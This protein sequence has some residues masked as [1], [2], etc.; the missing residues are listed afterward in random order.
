M[1]RHGRVHRSSN[2]RDAA[3]V[4]L[5]RALHVRVAALICSFLKGQPEIFFA[6][7]GRLRTCGFMHIGKAWRRKKTMHL[8]SGAPGPGGVCAVVREHG[9]PSLVYVVHQVSEISTSAVC[10]SLDA[11]PYF[12]NG[13]KK[14]VAS[15]WNAVRTLHQCRL[16]GAPEA[17]CERVGS[18]LE[19]I[20]S[21]RRAH[22]ALASHID[23]ARI[24]E[25]LIAAIGGPRD[26][27]ITREIV[28]SLR[29]RGYKSDCDQRN[30]RRHEREGIKVSLVVDRA[31]REHN[32]HL[33]ACGRWTPPPP[34]RQ[35]ATV[36]VDHGKGEEEE[37]E[38]EVLVLRP[39]DKEE[40]EE[41]Q[42]EEKEEEEVLVCNENPSDVFLRRASPW[43]KLS[44]KQ[45]GVA[46]E[47]RSCTTALGRRT[48]TSPWGKL[49][50]K[51]SGVAPVLRSRP[52]VSQRERLPPRSG[53]GSSFRT[54]LRVQRG[55]RDAA[56][57]QPH[58]LTSAIRG[59]L[60]NVAKNNK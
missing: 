2:W 41:E 36:E 35:K 39:A 24:R 22:A 11:D 46:P 51:Q 14:N 31:T 42:K 5:E 10:A 30:H 16:M 58:K 59:K 7:R 28:D 4:A 23:R 48:S 55:Q 37:E 15:A 26:A 50:G 1:P 60:R 57:C 21:K 40:E 25:A 43:G 33:F 45:S 29:R 32:E 49:S 17:C 52:T 34:L 54:P 56:H 6:S 18:T 38:E 47:L 44:G 12:C 3:A 13:V 20:W 53:H 8:K 9:P 27:R 19:G